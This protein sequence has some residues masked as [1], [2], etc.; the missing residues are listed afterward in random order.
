MSWESFFNQYGKEKIAQLIDDAYIKGE[1]FP[2]RKDVLQA[3]ELTSPQAIKV[4]ILGQDPYILAG[5]AHGLAFSIYSSEAKVPPTLK[6]IFKELENEFGNLR[7]DTNLTDWAMQGV[8]LLNTI[9][10]VESGKSLSHKNLGWQDFTTKTIEYLN[11]LNS[12]ICYILLGN[13]AQ[14]YR[15]YITSE[16]AHI[17]CAPH[18]SPLA[19]Y[20]GFFGSNIFKQT[21]EWLELHGQKSISWI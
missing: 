21:N 14:R 7:K 2:R 16:H 9:L 12:P 19:A 5:Q 15:T 3:Y 4:V 20:R 11:T 17:L 8:F 18:P 6:N 10:T 1:V 13:D